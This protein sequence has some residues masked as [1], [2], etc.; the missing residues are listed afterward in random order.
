MT[1]LAYPVANLAAAGGG[2][3]ALLALRIRP[4]LGGAYL[5]LLGL[6]LLGLAWV[7]WVREAL[8]AFPAAGSLMNY[9]FSIALA[10]VAVG[11][12]TWSTEAMSEGRWARWASAVVAMIPIGALV[13]GVVLITLD[14]DLGPADGWLSLAVA[15]TVVLAVA[16]QTILLRERTLGLARERVSAGRERTV[17]A[18]A[19][20]AEVTA[21]AAL[22]A[23]RRSEE[24]YRTV[25]D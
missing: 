20:E 25:A 6:A 12:A 3:V 10:I 11:A 23:Y 9:A 24:R 2:L 21:E 16:R 8:T 14:S 15:V 1:F 13:I 4:T 7:V 5:V 18:R 19:L 22:E 17:A